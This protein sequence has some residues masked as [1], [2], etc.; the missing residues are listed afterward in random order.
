MIMI[1]SRPSSG[2]GFEGTHINVRMKLLTLIIIG[3]G[4]VS[5]AKIIHQTVGPGGWTRYSCLHILGV[6]TMV[7]SSIEH[8]VYSSP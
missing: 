3:E 6:T 1:I 8:V 5:I 2:V 4:I 7:V